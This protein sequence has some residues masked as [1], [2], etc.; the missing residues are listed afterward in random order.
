MLAISNDG[1]EFN[2]FRYVDVHFTRE[3]K[4]LIDKGLISYQVDDFI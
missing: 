1:K 2:E 4:P 3:V